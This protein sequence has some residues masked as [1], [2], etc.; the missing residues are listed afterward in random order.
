MQD[1]EPCHR[2]NSVKDFSNIYYASHLLWP[3]NPSRYEI[4]RKFVRVG[5][6]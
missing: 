5:K 4:N 2:V 6:E 3:G 1:G